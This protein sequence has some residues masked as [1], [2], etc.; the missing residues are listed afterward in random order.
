M[1][2]IFAMYD[3]AYL[4]CVHTHDDI[5]IIMYIDKYTLNMRFSDTR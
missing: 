4:L 2:V 1:S 3:S 5:K